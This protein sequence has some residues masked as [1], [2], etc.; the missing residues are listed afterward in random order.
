MENKK[1]ELAELK[2]EYARLYEMAK[3][4]GNK[5][6]NENFMVKGYL[7]DIKKLEEEI[8]GKELEEKNNE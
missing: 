1:E 8:Y 7:E 5:N 6:P 3:R 4:M 2:R